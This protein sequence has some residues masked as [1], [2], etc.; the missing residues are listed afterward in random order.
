MKTL[1]QAIKYGIVG[2]SNTLITAIVI[3]I[4]MKCVGLSDNA[5]WRSSGIR[6]CAVFAACYLLQLGF[7]F[8]LNATLPIDGYYNQLIA[9]AF[10]TVI[11]FVFNKYYTFKE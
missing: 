10:Y 6:F 4:M 3:W 7:L 8:I 2:A 11:N 1:E 9:M 5:G